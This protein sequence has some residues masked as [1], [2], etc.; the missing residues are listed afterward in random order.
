MQRPSMWAV[1][2]LLSQRP[3]AMVCLPIIFRGRAAVARAPEESSVRS[4][5][6][7]LWE[8]RA[9]ALAVSWSQ[10]GCE[11]VSALSES[12][13]RGSCWDCAQT[14]GARAPQPWPPAGIR[15]EPRELS[16]LFSQA[17]QQQTLHTSPVSMCASQQLVSLAHGASIS[18]ILGA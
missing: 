12:P 8:H 18:A 11:Y 3:A 17:A 10:A 14:R 15:Y 2:R 13:T 5:L 6:S 4:E 1:Q 7:E 9:W 16:G